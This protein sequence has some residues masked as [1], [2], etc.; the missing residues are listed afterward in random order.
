[1][2]DDKKIGGDSTPNPIYAL[3]SHDGTGA[4]ITHAVLLGP[5]YEEWAKGFRVV[6]GAKR[7]LGFIDGTLKSKLSNLSEVED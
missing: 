7:K 4:K 2:G 6:L 1:M 3:S 5:N